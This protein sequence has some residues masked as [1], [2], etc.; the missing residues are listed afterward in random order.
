ML[1]QLNGG[2]SGNKTQTSLASLQTR[3]GRRC[4]RDGVTSD[5]LRR[6]HRS[7]GVGC[8]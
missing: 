7:G 8:L 1:R 2:L 5:Y 6:D 4:A 3:T